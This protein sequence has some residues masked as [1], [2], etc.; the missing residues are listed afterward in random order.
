MHVYWAMKHMRMVDIHRIDTTMSLEANIRIPGMAPL[1]CTTNKCRIRSP[2]MF[3]PD[4]PY[5]CRIH[6][7]RM[8]RQDRPYK[9]L[10]QSL[11]MFRPDRPYTLERNLL[12]LADMSLPHKACKHCFGHIAQD[13]N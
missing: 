11:R 7:P 4:R 8:F 13:R 2:R 3:R 1:C 10:I 6:S 9:C 5:K 12:E